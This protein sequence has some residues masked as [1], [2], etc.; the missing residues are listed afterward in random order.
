MLRAEGP[1]MTPDLPRKAVA[2]FTGTMFLLATVV[3]SGIMGE[4]LFDNHTGFALIANSLATGAALVALIY[5]FISISGA[6]LNPVV[7][8]V[9]ATGGGLALG[10]AGAFVVGQLTGALTGV[11]LAHLMFDLP[12]FALSQH[13]RTGPSLWLS[14]GIATFGLV[15]VIVGCAR[16]RPGAIPVVVGAYITAA[17]WFT[18]S[19]SFANPAVTVARALTDTFSGI[20]LLDVPG[21]VAAQVA[22]GLAAAFLLRWLTPAPAEDQSR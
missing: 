1:I 5:T 4:R 3:G 13:V 14:E 11:A 7:T 6:H 20:R 9:E 12:V 22:G 18:S 10:E 16:R 19:T 21:F 2:E 15:A 8:L 17:Y